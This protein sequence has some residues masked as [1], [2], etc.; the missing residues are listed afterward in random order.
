M[1]T[2]IKRILKEGFTDLY[3]FGPTVAFARVRWILSNRSLKS[4][5]YRNRIL[6]KWLTKRYSNLVKRY[7]SYQAENNEAA[8]EN[9]PVWGLWWQGEE[10]MPEI[11]RWCH[12][13]KVHAAGGHP[14]ILLDS[15]SVRDYV[16]FPPCV[17]EQYEKG[18]LRIQHLADM[19]RVQLLKTYGGI[20]L[21]AS[22]YCLGNIPQSDFEREVYSVKCEPNERFVS[23]GH[24]TT[25]AIGGKKGNTLCSFLNDLFIAHCESGKPFI[26]YYMFDCAIA[27]AYNT[28]PSVKEAIDA[29]PLES[30][31]NFWLDD[32]MGADAKEVEAEMHKQ[33][34]VQ[35]IR[36]S[37][38]LETL[39]NDG[40]L[41]SYLKQKE[42]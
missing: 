14:L 5:V 10:T 27:V 18:H 40:S 7:R 15:D 30:S 2:T 19:I 26:D 11:I 31:H 3:H 12:K 22:V 4:V 33:N 17:W 20:W 32:H 29:L 13:S 6:V 35:K 8:D 28:I 34:R 9:S 41:Y 25:Y 38:W 39:P 37:K 23:L 21:D 1:I 42:E 16:E 36:W 24:W